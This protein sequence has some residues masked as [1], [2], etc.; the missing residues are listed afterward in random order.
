MELE[1]GPYSPS[2]LDTATCGFAFKRLYPSKKDLTAVRPKFESLPQARGSATHEV[3]A[4]VTEAI[5]KNPKAVF[6]ADV[7]QSWVAAS[8]V[9]HPAAYQEAGPILDMAKL[10]IA[11]PPNLLTSDAGI[12]EMLA[13]KY[14]AG[15]FVECDYDDPGAF[16]RGR[17][18]IML[19]SDDTT[20]A[21]IYDHKTQPNIEDADTFQMGFYAWVVAKR[22]P[23]LRE[24]RTVLHF[25]RYGYY[26][27]PYVWTAEDLAKIEDEIITRVM[28]I[29]SRTSWEPTPHKN[30]QYCPYLAECPAM[31][32]YLQPDSEGHL[33]IK[34]GI[35][36]IL[37]NTQ[38]AEEVAGILTVLEELTKRLK[39]DLREHIE[40]SE[41]PVA[42]PGK[43]F[44]F[45]PDGGKTDW[46]HVNKF[47]R[48]AVYAI[49]E[50]HGV[51]PRKYMSFSESYYKGIWMEENEALV[52]ELESTFKTV[53]TTTFTS[54]K[55]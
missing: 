34:P 54:K 24:V 3:L 25:A 45:F 36:K 46:K 31:A 48:D 38:K 17:A 53:T 27:E 35:Q 10:Y 55:G 6:S 30:C 2:R 18:D 13:V 33:R 7:V 15:K 52:K 16:A 23:F 49:F 20:F 41:S 8:L 39:A 4:Q 5:C 47:Q 44:G 42:I 40:R 43:V 32:E 11:R 50:K 22:Y 1:F 28:F 26:S 12:E 9:R 37:G 21:I 51:D 19:I 14:E 29:E